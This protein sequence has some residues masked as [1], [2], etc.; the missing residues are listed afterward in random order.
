MQVNPSCSPFFDITNYIERNANVVRDMVLVNAGNTDRT[1]RPDLPRPYIPGGYS[2][3]GAT[4]LLNRL[5]GA[6]F[7][8]GVIY[9]QKKLGI[10]DEKIEFINGSVLGIRLGYMG[11]VAKAVNEA[12]ALKTTPSA[13]ETSACKEMDKA[14]KKLGKA[15]NAY[16]KHG[17]EAGAYGP[18]STSS[19]LSKARIKVEEKCVKSIRAISAD[20][21]CCV[22]S[23]NYLLPATLQQV[24]HNFGDV[25]MNG[26]LSRA[27]EATS[28]YGA[29]D[30]LD[31]YLANVNFD[32]AMAAINILLCIP[33][34]VREAAPP[35]RG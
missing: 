28:V 21:F 26:D 8:D 33:S 16:K 18:S 15:L 5:Q 30:A 25:P 11:T 22:I 1:L 4:I 31:L 27:L 9:I 34:F 2:T 10:A 24:Q 32:S 7:D 23:K 13:V 20:V 3:K 19:A 17:R 12:I 14:L 29:Q 35:E 6:A